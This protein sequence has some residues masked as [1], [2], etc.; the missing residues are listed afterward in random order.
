MDNI[1]LD[2]KFVNKVQE[3]FYYCTKRN[4]NYNGSFGNGKSYGAS[5][6]AVTLLSTFPKYRIGISRYSAKELSQS[7]MSTFFKICPMELYNEAYGGRR[8]DRDGYLRLI[9]GSEVFWMHLDDYSAVDLRGKE[10]NSVI[11]DQ[12]EEIAEE[13]YTT[14]D[15]RMERWDRAEIPP[16]M[17]A[18]AFPKNKFTGKPMPPCYNMALFNPETTLHWIYRHFHPESPDV[19]K[20][21]GSYESSE[22]YGEASSIVNYQNSSWFTASMADNPA[23]PDTLKA[24]YLRR[25]QSWI[26]RFY[27]GKWG[28]AGGSIHYVDSQ[29]IIDWARRDNRDQIRKLLEIIA[30][31]GIKY[32]VMDHGEG[33]PT[34]C[35]WFAYLSSSVMFKNF[36]VKSKGIHICYREYYQPGKIIKYHREMIAQLSGAERYYGNFADPDI[37]KKHSQKFG[38]FWTVADDYIDNREYT[39]EERLKAPSIVWQPADNNE[40]SCR[41]AVSEL[42]TLDPLIYNPMSIEPMAPA[43]YFIKQ[44]NTEYPHGCSQSI[45]QLQSAK[46]RKID[47][48]NGEDVYSD[49]RDPNVTDHAYDP[50]RYYSIMPKTRELPQSPKESPQFSFNR[51]LSKVRR[52][53]GRTYRNG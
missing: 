4:A 27:W 13:I 47:N 14:L 29:S 24:A 15:A 2:F 45:A 25:E 44:H 26:D 11:T 38:G 39:M 1:S 52:N 9:N 46:R 33:A 5:M 23:I 3:E 28:I 12:C 21:C 35:L 32:R 16:Y 50:I 41:D 22:S 49:E 8:N 42:L 10:F 48:I 53:K 19:E 20:Y 30:K 43:L 6:K 31:D 34:C 36:N 18:E 7:T 40:M 51:H 17:N 37:F